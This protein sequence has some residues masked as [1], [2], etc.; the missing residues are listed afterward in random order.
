MKSNTEMDIIVAHKILSWNCTTHNIL[1]DGRRT[2]LVWNGECHKARLKIGI[3]DDCIGDGFV[4]SPTQDAN[5]DYIVLSYVRENWDLKLL[6]KF[7]VT[8]KNMLFLKGR[9]LCM[10]SV[11]FVGEEPSYQ[12]SS[13]L[14]YCPGDYS[15]A[16]LITMGLIGKTCE[17]SSQE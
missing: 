17:T 7:E 9:R 1:W 8:L 6:E 16:A 10:I 15:R 5:D 4:F 3:C 14:E 12:I 11:G 13:V 2:R